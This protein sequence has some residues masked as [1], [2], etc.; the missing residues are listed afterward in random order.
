M[1]QLRYSRLDSLIANLGCI[2]GHRKKEAQLSFL[3]KLRQFLQPA[4]LSKYKS[5]S[6][7][8]RN[9]ICALK[10]YNSED[11]K[12][13]KTFPEPQHLD[14]L[15][16]TPAQYNLSSLEDHIKR[17]NGTIDLIEQLENS[18]VALALIQSLYDAPEHFNANAQSIKVLK[19][20]PYRLIRWTL[21]ELSSLPSENFS[22]G[23][24]LDLQDATAFA[25]KT[26]QSVKE[27]EPDWLVCDL[28]Q[29]KSTSMYAEKLKLLSRLCGL[30]SFSVPLW[31]QERQLYDF[32]KG[33]HIQQLGP[34]E[35]LDYLQNLLQTKKS[36][37]FS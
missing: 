8:E 23:T 31:Y 15:R 18:E 36:I 28:S 6:K 27:V 24:T 10:Q 33:N 16:S 17:K 5:R 34:V 4:D 26:H 20:L 32:V 2:I 30:P 14:L 11:V 35:L 21:V 25:E 3:L 12:I 37:L 29:W 9:L 7:E 13:S 22:N 19:Y 1:E